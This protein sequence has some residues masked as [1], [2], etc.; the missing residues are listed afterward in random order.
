MNW[1]LLLGFIMCALF[2]FLV[3]AMFAING[4]RW[5]KLE[6]STAWFLGRTARDLLGLAV[7]L[8]MLAHGKWPQ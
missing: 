5:S 6:V 2:A 1:T 7:L 3:G 8:A 4:E